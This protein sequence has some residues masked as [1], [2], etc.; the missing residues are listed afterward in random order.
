MDHNDNNDH[1]NN[2]NN[3]HDD[4]HAFYYRYSH[5]YGY[6]SRRGFS[7]VELLIVIVIIAVI[8]I[9]ILSYIA[10]TREDT[11]LNRA[12]A[13]FVSIF[14]ALELY[15]EDIGVYPA[16]TDR[17]IPPGLEVYLQPGLWPDAA[18]PGSVFDWD[19]W[20]SG[21]LAYSPKEQVYQ[22]SVRFC[23]I[24]GPLSACRFPQEPWAES[25]DVQSA[26]YFC[27]QG[28]CRSHASEP[29]S[30]PGYCVNC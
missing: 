4:N 3:N 9:I 21:D 27:V 28:P 22:I 5:C 20:S 16:D 26:V 24:G 10:G 6:N 25:F 17:D 7:I 15:H 11:Y 30:H 18:W 2:H 12:K 14:Q 8:A 1:N 19:N 23:P 13:E 29:V